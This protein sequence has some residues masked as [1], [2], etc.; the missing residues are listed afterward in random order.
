MTEDKKSFVDRKDADRIARR[1]LP[2]F[3]AGAMLR[4]PFPV[5]AERQTQMVEDLLPTIVEAVVDGSWPLSANG[6]LTFRLIG[7]TAPS[8]PEPKRN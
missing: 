2:D 6:R 4:A 8:V 3:V 5:S 7:T 1:D